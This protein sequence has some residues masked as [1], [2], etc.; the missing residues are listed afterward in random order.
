MRSAEVI[1][2]IKTESAI[3]SGKTNDPFRPLIEYW[4]LDGN[5]LAE[6]DEWDK[7]NVRK[8]VVTAYENRPK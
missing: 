5:L 2:V 8:G 3:G 1:Q 6:K 4:S 7:S